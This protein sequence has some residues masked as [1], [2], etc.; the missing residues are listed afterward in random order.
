MGFRSIKLTH[1]PQVLSSQS[2]RWFQVEFSFK[3]K[4][5]TD[6][7]TASNVTQHVLIPVL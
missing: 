5:N 6:N 3:L 4:I 2:Q 1:E 7:L